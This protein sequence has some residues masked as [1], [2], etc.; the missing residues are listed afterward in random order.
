MHRSIL[1]TAALLGFLLAGCHD[2]T[3]PATTAALEATTPMPERICYR[4]VTGRDTVTAYLTVR[5]T[6]VTGELKVLPAEKDRAHGPFSGTL[7]GNQLVA[8]WQR[9]GEGTIQVYEI[10]FALF[11]DSLQWQ[12]GERTLQGG[13]WVLADPTLRYQYKLVKVNCAAQQ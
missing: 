6:A 12:E 10:V 2:Q 1:A 9:A 4:Q 7:T 8:D 13:K 5:G 3:T 11:G